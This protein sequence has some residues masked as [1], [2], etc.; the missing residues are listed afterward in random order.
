MRCLIRLASA[1]GLALTVGPAPAQQ[2]TP[3]RGATATV[4]T[5]AAAKFFRLVSP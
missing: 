4:E 2:P 1:L 3:R 5:T